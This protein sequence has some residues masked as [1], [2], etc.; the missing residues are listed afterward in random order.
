MRK[1]LL[2]ILFVFATLGTGPVATAQPSPEAVAQVQAII[3]QFPNGG[4]GLRAAIARAVAADPSLAEAV[5]AAA[6]AANPAQQRSIGAGL[7]DAAAFFSRIGTSFARAAQQVI[8]TAIA[9]APPTVLAAFTFVANT[10][11]SQGGGFGV[12]SGLTIT[13]NRCISPSGP[14]FQPPGPPF[15][16]PGPPSN[17]PPF[18]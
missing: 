11:A 18:C 17:R 5:V 2:A 1:Y 3:A 14:G 16:P 8:Q 7:A 4:P 10:A 13:A 15:Q 12:P 6:A 9:S